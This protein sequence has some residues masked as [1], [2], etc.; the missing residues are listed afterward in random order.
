MS[1]VLPLK[2]PEALVK[3]IP[4]LAIAVDG[5][6][7]ICREK[8]TAH[9]GRNWPYDSRLTITHGKSSSGEVNTADRSFISLVLL[10]ENVW[11]VERKDFR[12]APGL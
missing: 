4:A 7:S 3:T 9:S 6:V 12:S 8:A 11:S 1:Q 5:F 10:S 2:G